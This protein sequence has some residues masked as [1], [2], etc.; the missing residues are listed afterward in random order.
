MDQTITEKIEFIK[1]LL[2]EFDWDKN[3]KENTKIFINEIIKML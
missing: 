1:T 2:M 3:T